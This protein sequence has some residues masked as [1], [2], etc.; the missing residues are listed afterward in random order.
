MKPR[1]YIRRDEH[2]RRYRQRESKDS[3]FGTWDGWQAA[4]LTVAD[5]PRFYYEGLVLH[6]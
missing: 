5:E 3:F 2:E 4:V 1:E 6:G